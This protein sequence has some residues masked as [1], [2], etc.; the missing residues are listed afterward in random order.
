MFAEMLGMVCHSAYYE[1]GEQ[2]VIL[3]FIVANL[4]GFIVHLDG[5]RG[6][7][8]WAQFPIEYLRTIHIDDVHKIPDETKI[9]LHHTR[10]YDLFDPTQCIDFL[11]HLIALIR[12][13]AAGKGNVGH[14][15]LPGDKIHRVLP[16]STGVS[17]EDE[18]EVPEWMV[19]DEKDEAEWLSEKAS[20]YA[21]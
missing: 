7:I 1:Q 9:A 15:R 4:K 19:M 10:S 14:L 6:S 13:L 2:M 8:F 20:G 16:P 3:T 12:Y 21:S 11:R 5:S 17:G 18:S